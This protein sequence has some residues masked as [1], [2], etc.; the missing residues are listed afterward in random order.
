MTA[1]ETQNLQTLRKT[2]R[3]A[4]TVVDKV[5]DCGSENWSMPGTDSEMDSDDERLDAADATTIGGP[6]DDPTPDFNDFTA[7]EVLDPLIGNLERRVDKDVASGRYIEAEKSQ[8][9]R[10]K[11][12]KEREAAYTISFDLAGEQEKLANIYYKQ[13]KFADGNKIIH[14]L[15]NRRLKEASEPTHKGTA[16]SLEEEEDLDTRLRRARHFYVLA[17]S[18]FMQYRSNGHTLLLE[19]SEKF[20]KRSFKLRLAARHKEN[21]MFLQSVQLL[22]RK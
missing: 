13:E 12:L 2:I 1:D 8:L 22:V 19:R 18:S 17:N 11:Y 3:V 4:R 14:T 20:A 16:I 15:L 7:L 5:S 9:R 10:I 21:Q 6:D